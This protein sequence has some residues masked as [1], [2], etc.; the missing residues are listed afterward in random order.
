VAHEA[1]EASLRG[2]AVVVPGF[3]NRALL[4]LSSL[5]PAASVA[6]ILGSRWRQAHQRRAPACAQSAGGG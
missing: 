6:G 5:L 3:L 4:S 1:V 2:R